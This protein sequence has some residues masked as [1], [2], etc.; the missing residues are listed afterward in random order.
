MQ[1]KKKRDFVQSFFLAPQE[2]GYFVLNDTLR[3][4]S[5]RRP[6][7]YP[8]ENGYIHSNYDKSYNQVCSYARRRTADPVLTSGQTL[9]ILTEQMCPV[10][11]RWQG[12]TRTATTTQPKCRHTLHTTR[13]PPC[14]PPTPP[15]PIPPLFLY[16]QR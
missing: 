2:K 16:H 3:Y 7:Q 8:K 14:T 5:E 12:I 10:F 11:C 13:P 6:G 1:G 9:A 15:R 4:L